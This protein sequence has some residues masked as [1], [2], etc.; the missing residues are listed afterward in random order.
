MPVPWD[1][2]GGVD[3]CFAGPCGDVAHDELWDAVDVQTEFALV[4]FETC[5]VGRMSESANTF[6]TCS[7]TVLEGVTVTVHVAVVAVAVV[8]AV[9]VLTPYEH[10]KD[11]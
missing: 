1:P 4:G 2:R 8:V 10:Q 5:M 7:D 3:A 9:V 6:V 11:T